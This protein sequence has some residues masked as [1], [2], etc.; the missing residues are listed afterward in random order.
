[1]AEANAKRGSTAA[2]PL[3]PHLQ[4][5]SLEVNMVMSILHR[6]TGAALYVGTVLVAWV[7]VA[8]ASGPDAF[9]YVTGL[10]GTWPGLFVLFGYTWAL[11]HHLVGGVR[12]FL[13]DTG[14]GYDIASIDLLSWATLGVSVGLT[15]L[16]W[17]YVLLSAGGVDL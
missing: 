8:A 7:L 6:I 2:R 9:A 17:G 16:I 12:H 1:M 4:V 3:S 14:R 5:Y 15:L 10:L 13:W 11:L